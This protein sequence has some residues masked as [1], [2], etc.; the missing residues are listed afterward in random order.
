MTTAPDSHDTQGQDRPER[1]TYTDD[2]LREWGLEEEF[3]A[4]AREELES[5]LR[6]CEERGPVRFSFGS[7]SYGAIQISDLESGLGRGVAATG[8][9]DLPFYTLY[10]YWDPTHPPVEIL[11]ENPIHAIQYTEVIGGSDEHLRALAENP[12]LKAISM[13]GLVTEEDVERARE[14]NE[15]DIEVIRTELANA[16]AAG[17]VT[18]EEADAQ[19]MP[20]SELTAGGSLL[21]DEGL[22]ALTG[23]ERLEEVSLR[24]GEFTDTALAEVLSSLPNLNNLR[25]SSPG[26]T[27]EFLNALEGRTLELI[28]LK[29]P[30]LTGAGL[31]SLPAFP[32]TQ[33]LDLVG[34]NVLD[35]LDIAA[36]RAAFPDVA[37]LNLGGDDVGIED[38]R[39]LEVYARFPGVEINNLSMSRKAI[40]KVAAKRGLTLPDQDA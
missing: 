17:E 20:K 29:G 35:G 12:R 19:E 23:H 14:A 8:D 28:S 5:E 38:D 39:M 11:R 4:E 37:S 26:V 18:Q 15:A 21:T 31:S 33:A 3:F 30:D 27:G 9:I 25:I 7:G 34:P 6:E 40:E 2:Q 22:R 16:V 32:G 24:G 10:M 13:Q 1:P 36:L